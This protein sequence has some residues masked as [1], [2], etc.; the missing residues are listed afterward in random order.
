MRLYFFFF[1]LTFFVDGVFEVAT[2]FVF[3]GVA[4]VA[5]VL[6]G[7]VTISL[8]SRSKIKAE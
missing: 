8:S 1:L 4:G 6:A 2:D 5:S 7:G 3:S